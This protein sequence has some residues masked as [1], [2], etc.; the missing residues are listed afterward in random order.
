MN[1]ISSSSDPH[2]RDI[3]L[4]ALEQPTLAERA[5]F[6]DSVCQ[7]NPA[8]RCAVDK[9]LAHHHDDGFLEAPAISN[10]AA[11][12]AAPV[13]E[14]PGDRIAGRAQHRKKLSQEHLT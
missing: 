9:L 2:P 13:S 4:E 3:F 6:L 8:L 10:A 14:Q 5:A 11:A 1:P 12:A 7:G